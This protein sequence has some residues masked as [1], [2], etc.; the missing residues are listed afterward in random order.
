MSFRFSGRF[1]ASSLFVAGLMAAAGGCDCG[2]GGIKNTACKTD[3]D[4]QGLA[5]A[6]QTQHDQSHEARARQQQHGCE[7]AP[8]TAAVRHGRQRLA[9]L[10]RDLPDS[11]EP[12]RDALYSL[13]NVLGVRAIGR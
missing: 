13:P 3:A 6:Q 5:E 1:A 9:G 2:G 8:G 10:R 12:E 4:C 11:I 7:H